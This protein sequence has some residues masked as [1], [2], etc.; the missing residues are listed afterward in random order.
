MIRTGIII[1]II[2]MS[3]IGFCQMGMDKNRARKQR[4][5]ISERTLFL[6][7]GIGGSFGSL[8]GM[9]VFHHK[10]KH[11]RFVLGIPALALIHIILLYI[12][13]FVLV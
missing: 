12:V 9:Y 8:L 13:F 2:L 5:R 7:A 11:L 6:T 4:W 3:L 1:Y 10:T